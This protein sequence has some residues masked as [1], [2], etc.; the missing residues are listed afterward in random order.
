MVR[1][2]A[3]RLLDGGLP[4]GVNAGTVGGGVA[5]SIEGTEETAH[6]QPETVLDEHLV[7]FDRQ[8]T[9]GQET[10]REPLTRV[11]P[12]RVEPLVHQGLAR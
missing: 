11:P 8:R 7:H 6:H 3:V 9:N 10:D 12:R 4:T 1:K 2:T 5:P